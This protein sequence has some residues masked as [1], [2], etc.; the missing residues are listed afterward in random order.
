MTIGGEAGSVQHPLIKYARDAGWTYI[1]RDGAL[2][3]RGDETGLVLSDTLGTQLERLNPGRVSRAQAAE[4]TRSL[5]RVSPT[6]AGNFA[7]WEF[8]RGTQDD[9]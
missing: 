9:L 3:L 7:A 2:A 4:L 6:L 8:L 5:T 1:T